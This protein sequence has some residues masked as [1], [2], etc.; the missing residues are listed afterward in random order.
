MPASVYPVISNCNLAEWHYVKGLGD[1]LGK[2]CHWGWALRFQKPKPGLVS[3]SSLPTD[4]DVV[5][6]PCSSD[7]LHA[8]MLPAII[9][10]D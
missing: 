5:F 1:L 3:F 10:I 6:N 4:V 7:Y 8:A 2:V 9:V